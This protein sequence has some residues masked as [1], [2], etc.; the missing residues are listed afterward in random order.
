MLHLRLLR[1]SRHEHRL[2]YSKRILNHRPPPTPKRLASIL[3]ESACVALSASIEPN[4][5]TILSCQESSLESIAR[6]LEERSHT[7]G[8]AV[9]S[10]HGSSHLG[11]SKDKGGGY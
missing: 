4:D 3:T 2:L 6:D 8:A 5:S 1:P 9:T 7:V 10:G 11:Q